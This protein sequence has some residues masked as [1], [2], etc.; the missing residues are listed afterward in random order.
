LE[1]R[2]VRRGGGAGKCRVAWIGGWYG[3]EEREGAAVFRSEWY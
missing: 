3:M 1:E 2:G